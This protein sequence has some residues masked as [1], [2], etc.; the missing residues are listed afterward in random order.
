MAASPTAPVGADDPGLVGRFEA[1]RRLLEVVDAALGGAGGVALVEGQTGM[2]KTRL[3]T[4]VAEAA[5]W[6]GA[7][8]LW[9]RH[10]DR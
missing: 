1:R 10:D 7:S 5:R 4:D 8:V 3:L 2:G 6:R 9:A